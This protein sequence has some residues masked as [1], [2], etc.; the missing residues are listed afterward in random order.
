MPG[1]LNILVLCVCS[2]IF[3]AAT[4][5][6][7]SRRLIL[8]T[9]APSAP[10]QNL[11]QTQKPAEDLGQE[12]VSDDVPLVEEVE[13]PLLDELGDDTDRD[14]DDLEDFDSD[15]PD[16]QPMTQWSLKPMTSLRASLSPTSVKIPADQSWQLTSRPMQPWASSEKVF[17]WSA[18]GIRYNPLIFEDVALERYGQTRGLYKQPFFSAAH[19]LK[20]AFLL[21]YNSLIDPVDTCDYPLGY[22]RPGDQVPCVK[23]QVLLRTPNR[24]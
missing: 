5:A 17:A 6:Q 20:S 1:K 16:P 7:E 22:C 19:Y 13:D 15:D 23:Q 4:N 11:E 8:I 10:I 9:G 21:P 3:A 2:L 14:L 24:R 18:P 12:D